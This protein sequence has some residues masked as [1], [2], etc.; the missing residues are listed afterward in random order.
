MCQSA[1][2]QS[3]TCQSATFSGVPAVQIYINNTAPLCWP[4]F[5]WGS[6]YSAL[7]TTLS[8]VPAVQIYINNTA[9]I[10]WPLP[11]WDSTQLHRKADC[12]KVPSLLMTRFLLCLWL[13]QLTGSIHGSTHAVYTRPWH[14][15]HSLLVQA[16]QLDLAYCHKL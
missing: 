1:T 8:G 14:K 3:A 7:Q 9:P 16:T 6:C 10:W 11:K 15:L 4:L 2:C 5:K 13:T 12:Q